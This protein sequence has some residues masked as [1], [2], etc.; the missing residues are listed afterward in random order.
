MIDTGGGTD[1]AVNVN[2]HLVGRLLSIFGA[3]ARLMRRGAAYMLS[4][5]TVRSGFHNPHVRR[6]EPL[7]W[8]R[9]AAV[10]RH[11]LAAVPMAAVRPS[12][13]ALGI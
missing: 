13:A 2:L 9:E 4:L 12:A 3:T 5:P 7:F 8:S 1:R 10:S 11:G 6:R